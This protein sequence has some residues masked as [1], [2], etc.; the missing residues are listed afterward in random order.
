MKKICNKGNE[1]LKEYY[2]S[3]FLAKLD[4]DLPKD[5]EEE[6]E[7][8]ECWRCMNWSFFSYCNFINFLYTWLDYF[9]FCCCCNYCCCCKQI[10]CKVPFFIITTVLYVLVASV[11][12]FGLIKSNYIFKGVSDTECSIL[13]FFNE[14]IEEKQ[15]QRNQNGLE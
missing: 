5:E 1:E 10:S 12:I 9:C 11:F 3:G 2:S 13:K 7:N 8:P 15:K 4:I 14:I 6:K